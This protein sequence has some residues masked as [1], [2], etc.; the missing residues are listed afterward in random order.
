MNEGYKMSNLTK[1]TLIEVA[2]S[3]SRVW[4]E[5]EVSFPI[6]QLNGE[7]KLRIH[8]ILDFEKKMN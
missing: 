7:G 6:H 5:V 4:V 1:Y 3:T 8:D 2:H